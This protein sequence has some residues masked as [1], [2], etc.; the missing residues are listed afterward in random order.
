MSKFSKS[1][2]V[3]LDHNSFGNEQEQYEVTMSPSAIPDLDV[4]LKDVQDLLEFIESPEMSKLENT[5]LD[6]FT[7]ANELEDTNNKLDSERPDEQV[8][9]LETKRKIVKIRKA[10]KKKKEQF[11]AFVYGKFN[12]SIPM[13]IISLMIEQERYENLDEL[14]NMFDTLKAVKSGKKDINKEAEKFGEKN[15]QKY[16]YPKFGGKDNFEKVMSQD[17]NKTN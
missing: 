7:L 3:K 13:K 16:V 12:N 14:L 15:K 9:I 17:P 10:A 4:M 11:E 1:E 5:F 8:T 6:E 2:S